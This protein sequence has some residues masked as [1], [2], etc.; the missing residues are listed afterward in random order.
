MNARRVLTALVV[1][2][3]LVGWGGQ[4]SAAI[5]KIPADPKAVKLVG[6][7]LKA[8]ATADAG[9]RLAAVLPLVHKSLRTAD[10]KDLARTVKDYSYK[11]ATTGAQHYIYPPEIF[12]VHQGNTVTVGFKETA[13]RGRKDKYFVKKKAGVAG[14]PAPI[15]IFWPEGGGAPRVLDFGSL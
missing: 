9:K 2:A 14:R 1:A 11:K 6:Q 5:K 4:A 12:E 10:G 8:L 7:V 13:E 3:V 15:I